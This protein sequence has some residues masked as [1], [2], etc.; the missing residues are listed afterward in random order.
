MQRACLSGLPQRQEHGRALTAQ[1]PPDHIERQLRGSVPDL[2]AVTYQYCV[3]H[4]G[5]R[6]ERR[7]GMIDRDPHGADRFRRCAAVRTGDPGDAD[8][9]IRARPRSGA[10]GHRRRNLLTDGT[11]GGHQRRIDTKHSTS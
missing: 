10:V 2:F 3:T 6:V 7:S 9:N 1:G 11:I 8:P 4:A 5:R